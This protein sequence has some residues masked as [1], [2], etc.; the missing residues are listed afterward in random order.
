MDEANV[1]RLV[2][3]VL[4]AVSSGA[5]ALVYRDVVRRLTTL[6]KKSSAQLVAMLL[7]LGRIDNVP[8]DLIKAIRDAIIP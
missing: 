1:W 3:S 7:L 5:L 8:S 2:I 6:E 4:L